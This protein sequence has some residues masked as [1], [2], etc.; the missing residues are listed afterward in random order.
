MR[1][2][3]RADEQRPADPACGL[4]APRP[5][6]AHS[7]PVTRRA[8]QRA[9]VCGTRNAGNSSSSAQQ[10]RGD[11]PRPPAFA[12]SADAVCYERTAEGP[13]PSLHDPQTPIILALWTFKEKECQHL[14]Y[15]VQT[16]RAGGAGGIIGK[17]AVTFWRLK[18]KSGEKPTRLPP[19][20][21]HRY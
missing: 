13:P 11:T 8:P 4:H 19:G 16:P 12:L 21:C 18:F 2:E 10:S 9:M 15:N 7:P 5:R 20:R 1:P 17:M 3:T 6:A 14:G